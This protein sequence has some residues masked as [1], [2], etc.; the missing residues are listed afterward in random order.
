[1]TG[2]GFE[3]T[4]GL[5]IQQGLFSESSTANHKIGTRM[6]LADGRV[7]YYFLNGA[8]T[9]AV[10]KLC[11]SKAAQANHLECTAL[12][13]ASVGDKSV[14]ITVGAT[15]VTANEYAEG[16]VYS[17]LSD[18]LGYHYKIKSHT[19]A[20]SAGNVTVT[21]YDPIQV[22]TTSSTEWSFRYNPFYAVI[23]QATITHSVCGV[24]PRAFTASY[25]GWM[26][27]WGPAV[28]LGMDTA[29]AGTLIAA[30]TT[31]GSVSALTLATE[32]TVITENLVG[33]M[34]EANVDG[35]YKAVCLQIYP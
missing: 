34:M 20:S 35:D 5:V 31:D 26:Q 3:V 6:Q 4:T 7:F 17:N 19:S 25:Y 21:L 9:L 29:A 23:L 2:R 13:T 32:D 24:P 22:A 30:G 14:I 18:G 8:S 10:G 27:T 15:A 11:V 1:M 33:H 28:V 12:G 16:W